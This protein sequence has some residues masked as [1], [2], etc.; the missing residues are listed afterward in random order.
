M[1]RD[2]L[3]ARTRPLCDEMTVFGP[4]VLTL[5]R[6]P[7]TVM[8]IVSSF[9]VFSLAFSVHKTLASIVAESTE[10]LETTISFRTPPGYVAVMV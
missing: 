2:V 5:H 6:K 1:F 8:C 7:V 4:E 10:E 9:Y 3:S